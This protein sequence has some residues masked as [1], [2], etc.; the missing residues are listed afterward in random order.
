MWL[1]FSSFREKEFIFIF[2]CGLEG[3][4]CRVS[5]TSLSTCFHCPGEQTCSADCQNRPLTGTV[6]LEGGFTGLKVHAQGWCLPCPLLCFLSPG[7]GQ[8]RHGLSQLAWPPEPSLFYL[9]LDGPDAA[10]IHDHAAIWRGH[11][12]Q[13]RGNWK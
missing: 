8:T 3:N 4:C 7:I 12:I 9:Q 5:G 10:V 13:G 1:Y 11:R 2:V 6:L